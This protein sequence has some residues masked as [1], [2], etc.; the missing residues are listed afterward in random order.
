VPFLLTCG[1]RFSLRTQY[2]ASQTVNR[3]FFAFFNNPEKTFIDLRNKMA[4]FSH[5]VA[6]INNK[7]L[8]LPIFCRKFAQINNDV[9]SCCDFWFFLYE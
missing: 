7:N 1:L 5:R 4:V 2:C 9:K 6:Q 8:F 3:I